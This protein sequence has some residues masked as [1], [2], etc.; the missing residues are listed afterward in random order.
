MLLLLSGAAAIMAIRILLDHD[1]KEENITLLSLLMAE[2]GVNSIAYAFPRVNL[3]TTAVDNHINQLCNI[4]PG[5]GNFGDRYY[6]T[7]A[8][9]LTS[10][11]EAEIFDQDE[12]DQ[13]ESGSVD[14]A[15][16]GSG[17]P[18]KKVSEAGQVSVLA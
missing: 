2:A 10:D 18:R 11:D 6:G 3:V 13:D 5:M 1:V 16:E 4:I 9:G 14:S 8:V 15:I 7:D 17:G 12:I